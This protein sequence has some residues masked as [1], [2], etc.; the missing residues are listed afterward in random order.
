MP[1]DSRIC[2]A[3]FKMWPYVAVFK[4]YNYKKAQN[5]KYNFEQRLVLIYIYICK[6][7][8]CLN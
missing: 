4:A 5:E 6:P 8:V 7:C 3:A 2:Y 1:H